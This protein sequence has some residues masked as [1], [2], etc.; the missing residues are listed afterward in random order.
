MC[1]STVY[2]VKD[3]EEKLVCQYVSGISVENGKVHLTDITG[4]EIDISG[5]I[6]NVDL[7]KNTVLVEVGK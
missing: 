4:N 3:N 7:I 6:K 5:S 1:L 2:E